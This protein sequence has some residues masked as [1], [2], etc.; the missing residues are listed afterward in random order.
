MNR[1]TERHAPAVTAVLLAAPAVSTPS[2]FAGPGHNPPGPDPRHAQQITGPNGGGGQLARHRPDG[3]F[4][5]V[6]ATGWSGVQT[7]HHQHE[8]P[9]D[10]PVQQH[11]TRWAYGPQPSGG[12]DDLTP[13]GT[14][15]RN[16]DDRTG[17][18]VR[19]RT[20]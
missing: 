11:P 3:S 4:H 15:P 9:L 19:S 2:A 13:P 6:D 8:H 7:D 18:T 14:T 12:Q 10:S 17:S 1:R 20:S 16:A 5:S